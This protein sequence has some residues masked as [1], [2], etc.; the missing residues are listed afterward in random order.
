MTEQEIIGR[1]LRVLEERITYGGVM[2][3]PSDVKNFCRLRLAGLQHEVFG[4]IW[5]NSQNC[6]I[7]AVDMFRGTLTQASVYPRE[8]VKDGLF[9][10]AA[11]CILYHNH[12]SGPLEPSRADE[13]LTRTLKSALELVD[14]RVLDHILVADSGAMSFAERGLV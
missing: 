2:G 4:V 9:K 1:A 13:M 10:N 5:L 12:P 7:E 14:I 6:L 8:V 11:A 3:A